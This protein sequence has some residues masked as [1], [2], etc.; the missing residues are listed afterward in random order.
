MYL[1]MYRDMPKIPPAFCY[2]CPFQ[3]TYP[4]CN[5]LCAQALE[6]AIC[7]AWTGKCGRH[8]LPSQLSVPLW[9]L[10]LPPRA[11]FQRVREICDKYEVLFIV[12]EVMTAL[13]RTGKMWGIEHWDVTP[14]HYRP[15]QKP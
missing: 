15:R 14:R 5:L 4:E 7:Q 11:H 9:R 12:D 3:K 2:R 1:P 10:Y 13:G 8:L 6:D